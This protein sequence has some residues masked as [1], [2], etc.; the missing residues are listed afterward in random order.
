MVVTEAADLTPRAA[1]TWKL[2]V[3]RI[4]RSGKQ[5]HSTK[6]L[7]RRFSLADET[8]QIA[9]RHFAGKADNGEKHEIC[10]MWGRASP[11]VRATA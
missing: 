4:A 10:A 8:S 2:M 11:P 1:D 3:E 7:V 9:F 6:T 5:H